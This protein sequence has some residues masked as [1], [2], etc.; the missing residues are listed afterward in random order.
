LKLLVKFIDD[1]ESVEPVLPV[2]H[3]FQQIVNVLEAELAG[4]NDR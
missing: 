3:S 4:T 2:D 1:D